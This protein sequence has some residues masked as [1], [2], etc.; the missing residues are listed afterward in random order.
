MHCRERRTSEERLHLA[1]M[2]DLEDMCSEMYLPDVQK[3][4]E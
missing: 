3:C 4:K 2:Y 1:D